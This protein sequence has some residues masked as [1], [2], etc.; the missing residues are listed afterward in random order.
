MV[1]VAAFLGAPIL[2]APQLRLLFNLRVT[3]VIK[4]GAPGAF[5]AGPTDDPAISSPVNLAR[6]LHKAAVWDLQV[7]TMAKQKVACDYVVITNPADVAEKVDANIPWPYLSLAAAP[8]AAQRGAIVQTGN[9]TG[10]RQKFH[11]LG[12]SLDDMAD[13]AKLAAMLPLMKRVKADCNN[14]ERF[15]LAGEGPGR[16]S[17]AGGQRRADLLPGAQWRDADC[18]GG[19]PIPAARRMSAWGR[20]GRHA[21]GS[22][23]ADVSAGEQAFVVR[24]AGEV[25][26]SVSGQLALSQKKT[27][28]RSGSLMT[29]T[30]RTLAPPRCSSG[31]SI[32]R[33]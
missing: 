32:S 14:A 13:E 10:D 18:R 5:A 9:Y 23:R 16:L 4:V 8:L 21:G 3:L 20:R 11:D 6:R 24:E 27:T 26:R 28:G 12:V 15:L 29:K 2:V 33:A 30:L 1:P 17:L 22:G 25:R 31:R 19:T 7:Q